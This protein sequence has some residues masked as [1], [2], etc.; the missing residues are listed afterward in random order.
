L[1]IVIFLIDFV[2]DKGTHESFQFSDKTLEGI[3][4]I[5]VAG[6]SNESKSLWTA[7]PQKSIPFALEPMTKGVHRLLVPEYG[8]TRDV[9]HGHSAIRM[10]ICTQADVITFFLQMSQ[11]DEKL[12]RILETTL[13]ELNVI[14]E[15]VASVV[16]CRLHTPLVQAI[17]TLAKFNISA[18]AVLDDLGVLVE[19]LSVSDLRGISSA[20]G[21]RQLLRDLRD[22]TV[23]EFITHCKEITTFQ[24]GGSVSCGKKHKLGN[25]MVTTTMMGIHRIWVINS[26]FIPV[27]V[28]T[29]TDMISTVLKEY[30]Q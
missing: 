20:S 4:I 17:R 16:S 14:Q 12:N 28:V 5:E 3:R 8:P 13:E 25:I 21:I 6:E 1:D 9:F 26:E 15:D 19:T 27:G 18:M 23:G 2:A 29:M 10:K 7:D 24:V 11:V 22:M 30:Y